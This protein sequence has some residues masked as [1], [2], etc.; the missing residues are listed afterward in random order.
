MCGIYLGHIF[1][2]FH[3]S[4]GKHFDSRCYSA[5]SYLIAGIFQAPLCT[6]WRQIDNKNHPR[7]I[8][9]TKPPTNQHIPLP[10]LTPGPRPLSHP[11]QP[12]PVKTT[13][14]QRHRARII[15]SV[16]LIAQVRIRCLVRLL[17]VLS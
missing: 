17:I 12:E 4:C 13:E 11:N 6:V 8:N 15:L 1:L 3:P 10:V 16:A 2:Y 9:Q 5:S 14:P 7:H